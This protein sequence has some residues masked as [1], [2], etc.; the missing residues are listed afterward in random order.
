MAVELSFDDSHSVTAVVR[1]LLLI[2]APS[3]S[4]FHDGL[5]HNG[6]CHDGLSHDVLHHKLLEKGQFSDS[7]SHKS[8]SLILF[9]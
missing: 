6:L 2:E 7:F 8:L 3:Q 9:K 4:L 1:R 5:C